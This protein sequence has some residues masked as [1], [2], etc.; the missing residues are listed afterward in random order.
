MRLGIDARLIF[1]TG[2]GVYIRNLLHY[3]PKYLPEDW[4]VFVYLLK[5]DYNKITLSSRYILRPVS[6]RWHTLSEQTAF[7]LDIWRDRLDLMHFTYFSFP[8]FYKRNFLI[9]LHDLIPLKY[10]TGRASSKS[11]FIY[12]FKHK[13]YSYLVSYA[14]D[15]ALRILTPSRTVGGE[16]SRFFP[17]AKGKIEIVYNGL[18][19]RFDQI[20]KKFSKDAK[21]FDYFLY[22]G[23][24]YPHKNVEFLIESFLELN[25]KSKLI[26]AGPDDFFADRLKKNFAKALLKG[27]I[28][29]RHN[30]DLKRLVYL[31]LR[32][33]ALVHPSLDEG[34][35]L[36]VL[37]ALSLGTPVLASDIKVFRELFGDFLY[38]FDPLSKE[39]LQ[40]QL[41]KFLS[42]LDEKKS[43][44]KTS[45]AKNLLKKYNFKTQIRKV[46][47][48]YKS[49]G[50]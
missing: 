39:S 32:A 6:G 11:K 1:Q 2:V 5:K 25:I 42:L 45:D 18:D 38:F 12:E 46:A 34:F 41:L 19:Y 14:A 31:Y 17:K 15:K 9:T 29:F 47:D 23:N 4:R 7:L 35:G 30:L 37:E 10:K 22:V 13:A 50:P 48:M 36:P 28:E 8:V 49:Y 26:L 21:R 33:K 40:K 3:L 27:K 20:S 44:I 16:I 43:F 24:F